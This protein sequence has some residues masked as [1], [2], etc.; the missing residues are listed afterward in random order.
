MKRLPIA[1]LAV[2]LLAA[3]TSALA[4]SGYGDR[5]GDQ[6]YGTQRQADYDYARV[7]RVDPVLG[8]GYGAYNARGGAY[9]DQRCYE[10]TT[11]GG[12]ERDGYDP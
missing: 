11:A 8:N 4:Q 6:R 3:S 9:G 12:Y 5:Y 7:I 1:L 2:G 10:T